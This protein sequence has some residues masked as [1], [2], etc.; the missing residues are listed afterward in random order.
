MKKTEKFLI[1]SRQSLRTVVDASDGDFYEDQAGNLQ[2]NGSLSAYD[3]KTLQYANDTCANYSINDQGFLSLSFEMEDLSVRIFHPEEAAE[4]AYFFNDKPQFEGYLSQS[5]ILTLSSLMEGIYFA[6]PG[7]V[8]EKG[9]QLLTPLTELRQ[10]MTKHDF[11]LIWKSLLGTGQL[12]EVHVLSAKYADKL[13][14]V[15]TCDGDLYYQPA[16]NILASKMLREVSEEE[17]EAASYLVFRLQ[18][19]HSLMLFYEYLIAHEVLKRNLHEVAL[20]PDDSDQWIFEYPDNKLDQIE[21]AY[22]FRHDREA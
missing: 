21:L 18:A 20:Q 19:S 16:L 4:L 10:L 12:E 17:A 22:E 2:L 15:P 11:K 3:G 13:Q 7:Y 5:K 9:E 6:I 1:A 14:G 8:D